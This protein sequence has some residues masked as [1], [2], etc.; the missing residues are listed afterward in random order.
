MIKNNDSLVVTG[1]NVFDI[2]SAAESAELKHD[3]GGDAPDHSEQDIAFK[4]MEI[5]DDPSKLE[6]LYNPHQRVL[7]V[8]I[9]ELLNKILTNLSADVEE[10][11]EFLK[12]NYV[13]FAREM[14]IEELDDESDH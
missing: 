3:G 4:I 5:A 11:M 8:T 10:E 7:F 2:K 13:D 6:E 9:S 14:A 1:H 12:S